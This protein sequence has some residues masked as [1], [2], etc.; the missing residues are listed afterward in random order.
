MGLL[1]RKQIVP[2]FS[3]YKRYKPFLRKEFDYRCAYCAIHEAEDGGSK[4]FHID[5]YLPK[6]K[7]KEQECEYTN[8]L[9]SCMDCNILK[10]EY[11]EN[12]FSKLKNE[13]ILNPCL[14]DFDFHYNRDNP[15]WVGLS[16]ASR[17]NIQK[18]RLNSP[19]QVKIRETRQLFFKKIKELENE[20]IALKNLNA[21]N[22]Y[23]NEIETTIFNL[24]E[25]IN[26]Y[27]FKII[28]PLD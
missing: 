11:Y 5:H 1:I 21:S 2:L 20:I 12:W 23:K 13:Y 3:S 14:H 15:M 6:N 27:K 4:K 7:F 19:K 25:E 8:L 22:T 9:Y 10:G 18:L 28:T 16:N 17:W 26:L 24:E